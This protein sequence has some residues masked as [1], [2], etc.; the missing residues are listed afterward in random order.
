MADKDTPRKG[1]SREEEEMMRQAAEAALRR[2]EENRNRRILEELM[3]AWL[4]ATCIDSV[5]VGALRRIV[6]DAQIDE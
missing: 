4:F 3:R 2:R 5:S 1:P 6:S